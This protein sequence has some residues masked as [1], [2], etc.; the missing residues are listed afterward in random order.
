LLL[1]IDGPE[2]AGKTTL[3]SALADQILLGGH[4]TK[5]RKWGKLDD[6]RWTIDSVY[7]EALQVDS[8]YPGLVIWDRSWASEAVYG[9]LLNRDRRLAADPWLG[10]WLYGRGV[11]LKVMVGG[12][13]PSV[14]TS[15][16]DAEDL[17][18]EA[19]AEQSA[20]LEYAVRYGWTVIGHTN[21]ERLP[22][23]TLVHLMRLRISEAYARLPR[24]PRQ[25]CG[26]REATAVFVG[27]EGPRA[28]A[29][30]GGWLP[31]TSKYTTMYGRLL[32][33]TAFHV[34]WTNAWDDQRQIFQ[35]ARLVIACGAT[36]FEWAKEV[37]REQAAGATTVQQVYHPAALYRWGR[38]KDQIPETEYAIRTLI[39]MYLELDV[40]NEAHGEVVNG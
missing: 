23:D 28:D 26:P 29:L 30:V 14:M 4:P 3:V 1:V 38:L 27:E 32:G 36:A 21:R 6:G 5:I 17:P 22:L 40:P 12:P 2:K 15:V 37:K 10:E 35:H 31:F 13:H 18:V 9:R 34:G 7:A 11:D 24:D 20:F 16:H 25:W 8:L 19:A 39:K 33:N